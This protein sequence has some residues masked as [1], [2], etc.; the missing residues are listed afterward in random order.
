MASHDKSFLFFP[1]AKPIDCAKRIPD[2]AGG[3]RLHCES[4]CRGLKFASTYLVYV[5][6]Q[7]QDD[8]VQSWEKDMQ[9]NVAKFLMAGL[10][11]IASALDGFGLI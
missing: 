7:L 8:M 2:G 11:F 10:F 1:Q 3:D 4:I 6:R 5:K 9:D